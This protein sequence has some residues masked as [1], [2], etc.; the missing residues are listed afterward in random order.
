[1]LRTFESVLR[2]DDLLYCQ[3]ELVNLALGSS[4]TGAPQLTRAA[5]GPAFIVVRLPP[6]TIAEQVVPPGA[7]EPALPFGAG[8]AGPSRLAF[9]VPDD[10]PAV[11]FR[12]DAF[13]ALMGKANLVIANDL[14][15]DTTAIECPDR[16]LLV[17]PP[18]SRLVHRTDAVTS[19]STGVTELWH[20]TLSD[21][22]TGA[23]P[24]LQAIANPSDRAD[25]PFATE[26][27]K[28]DR[29]AIVTLCAQHANIASS[30]LRLTTLGATAQF[31][32]DWPPVPPTSTLSLTE[33][34][35]QTELGRDRYVRTVHQGYLFPFGHRAAITTVTQRQT[36]SHFPLQTAEFMQQSFLTILETERSYDNLGAYP[37]KGREMPFVR[38]SIASAPAN[39]VANAPIAV[40][41][42]LTDRTGNHIDCN[43][44]VFFVTA[45]KAGDAGQL[46]TL[47]TSFK[48]A[49]PIAL[50]GQRVA[51][52]DNSAGDTSLNIDFIAFDTKLPADLVAAAVPPFLPF[53]A[54]AQARI[55]ALEQMVGTSAN[56]TPA[57]QRQATSIAFHESYVRTGFND[58]KQVFAKFAPLA[59]L[60]IPPE[61]AGGVAAPKF[62]GIDG[63]SRLTGPVAGVDGF[64]NGS[65]LQPEA[66]VGDAKLLGLIA[67]KDVIAAVTGD[68]DPFPVAQASALFDTIDKAT[69]TTFLPRPV[70][71]TVST[72]SG[73]ETRFIWKPRISG[74]LPAILKDSPSLQLVLKGR[75][76]A[77][78]SSPTSSP[79]FSVQGTLSNFAL[80]LLGLVKVRFTSLAF[81]SQSGSK[82]DVKPIVAGVEFAGTL[83]FVE[84]LQELLPTTNLSRAPQIQTLPDG[85]T[86]RYGSPIPS[87]S[88]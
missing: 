69:S 54:T 58:A 68:A 27:K 80:S 70:I 62:P 48:A 78:V 79:A 59:S 40:G 33:W 83:A 38:A 49:G 36:A 32:S 30:L 13:L 51:L 2:A 60:V 71:N 44:T 87:A 12:L 42:L 72:A 82:V 56:A 76:T 26:L 23:S 1:M 43:A 34:E 17:P 50:R 10:M 45:D 28:V 52:A 39:A 5:A 73:V 15:S 81:S 53:M 14:A 22:A 74:T 57:A 64:V 35:H 41:L 77:G 88:L 19:Q 4:A 86:V 31:K 3:F 47:K 63:L 85:V 7:S 8:L 16:L 65:T 66:L 29:D 25:R 46:G 55:P 61:R 24:R 37:G 67:L 9:L 11:P 20:T 75:I 21:P 6:Q 84:K 18:S